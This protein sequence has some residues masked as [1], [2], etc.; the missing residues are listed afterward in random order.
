MKLSGYSVKIAL[1][2][3]LSASLSG[4]LLYWLVMLGK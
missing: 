2:Y 1:F 4:M 3:L